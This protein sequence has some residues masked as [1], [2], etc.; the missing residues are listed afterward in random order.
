MNL[1]IY[2]VCPSLIFFLL[3]AAAGNA[4][5]NSKQDKE[6]LYL[7]NDQI[8]VGLLKSHGG[9]VAYL[10]EIDSAQNV[11]NHYDHGRLIQQSYYG[12]RDGSSWDKKNWRYN[13]VQG[14]S[15]Q[16]IPAKVI[17]I[18]KGKS[19]A[20]VKTTP[21]HWAT[22][23]LLTE[24]EM[25]QKVTLEENL[26][27]INFKFNYRGTTKHPIH[28]QELPAV[29]VSAEFENLVAYTGNEPWKNRQTSSRIPGWPN[30]TLKM[31][32]NWAAYLNNE[33]R[34]LGV[35]VPGTVNATCYRYLGGNG[36]NCSY[37]AP[38]RQFALVPKLEFK[39]VAYFTLGTEKEIRSRFKRLNQV[40]QEK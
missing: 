24:C 26:L 15:Y 8:K 7:H 35:F 21:R 32:E 38:L 6:W 4:Q 37:I 1:D 11:L 16:G 23:K 17:E 29:F 14:G 9:A 25:E 22:G 40:F 28:D 36:S 31:T 5:V 13:P 27:K 33:G 30:E 10:S 34:G 3:T 19:T 39:Y 12:K 18:R 2:R 20:Y